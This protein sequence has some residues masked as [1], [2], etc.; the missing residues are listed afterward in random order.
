MKIR[1]RQWYMDKF[2]SILGEQFEIHSTIY[3]KKEG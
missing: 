3:H 1:K 2:A